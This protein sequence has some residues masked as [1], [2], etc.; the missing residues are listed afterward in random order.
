V[1]GRTG[2]AG[3]HQ[4]NGK[5]TLQAVDLQGILNYHRGEELERRKG[6]RE[7][8]RGRGKRSNLS[9]AITG[10]PTS[11]PSPSLPLLHTC[12]PRAQLQTA[13]IMAVVG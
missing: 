2:Q 7:E 6:G 3:Q 5:C 9:R 8:R 1:T 4:G 10:D 13:P 12:T 11:S